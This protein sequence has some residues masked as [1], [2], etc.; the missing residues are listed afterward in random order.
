MEY[1]ITMQIYDWLG[2]IAI[3]TETTRFSDDELSV[4]WE[5]VA[6]RHNLRKEIKE[7]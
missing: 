4:L 2:G 3:I 6:K 7:E 5:N 1:D